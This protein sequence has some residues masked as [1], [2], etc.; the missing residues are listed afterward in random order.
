MA[1][2]DDLPPPEAPAEEIRRAADEIV[3]RPEFLP[4]P[5]TIWERIVGW[6][7]DRLSDLLSALFSGGRTALVAWVALAV[8]VAAVAFLIFK[9][10]TTMRANP[11]STPTFDVTTE[12]R[13][14]AV[15]WEREAQEHAAAGRWRDALR[16]R[17]RA[18]VAR[19]AAAGAVDEVPGR[20]AG[21]YRLEVRRTRPDAAPSFTEATD[22][23]ERA[24]YG[25]ADVDTT[26]DE[27]FRALAGRVLDERPGG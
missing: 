20:T 24:W 4:E 13:R 17:Y 1:S 12:R 3:S 6:F 26:D 8:V 27:H 10:V 11:A 19:L 21:E 14:P 2:P 25:H 18:L 22:I 5:Q 9:I 23:F 16:C 7:Q 15:D